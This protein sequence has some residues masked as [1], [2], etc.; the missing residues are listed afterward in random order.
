MRTLGFFAGALCA[1][2]TMF[3]ATVQARPDFLC[4]GYEKMENHAGV[5]AKILSGNT[6]YLPSRGTINTLVVFARFADED[7]GD[8]RLPDFADAL[9]AP[10]RPGSF[11]HFYHTMS[12]G[13][14]QVRGTVLPQRYASKRPQS[15]Y[16]A[17]NPGEPGRYRE[18]VQEILEKVDANYDLGQFDNDGP[19]NIPDSGDDDGIVDYIFINLLSVP[20]HFL[21]G[22][23]TG[24]AG[25]GLER[26]YNSNDLSF[27][28]DPIRIRDGINRGAI[29]QA[30]SFARTVG[31]M[32]HEFGHGLGLPDLYDLEYEDPAE[33]SAGIGDWGLMGW[34][35]DGWHGNDGPNPFCAWSLE[36]LGWIGRDNARLVQV[37]G[38][39]TGLALA[40]LHQQG[41]IC[42]IPLRTEFTTPGAIYVQE[43]LLL[44]ERVRTSHYY[45]RHLPAEGLLI[46]HIRP[47]ER[48]K[49]SREATKRV[50]LVCADGLYRDAGRIPDPHAGRDDLDFWAHE[51]SYAREHGGNLGDATDPFDG[52]H[53]TRFDLHTNP[54]TAIGG[55]H[56]PA[57]TGLALNLQRRGDTML[58]NIQQPRWSGTIREEVHWLGQVV[59]DGDLEIAPEGR[60]VVYSNTIVHVAGTD[61]LQRGQDPSRCELQVR[62]ELKIHTGTLY[63]NEHPRGIAPEP[64]IFAAL[65]PG[66]T[67][68]GIVFAAASRR[69][70]PA[71]G[72]VLR[73]SERGLVE[74]TGL[75][76]LEIEEPT[77]ILEESLTRPAT[78]QLLPNFPNPFNPQTTIQYVLPAAARVRL[79]VY[80]ALGQ[81]VRIL[82]DGFQPAGVQAAAWDGRDERGQDAASG[83]Y[84]YRLEAEG[85]GALHRRMTLLR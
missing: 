11:T 24:M 39:T 67:W 8:N 74:V 7:P 9:F 81:K 2:S 31:S 25:L 22:Q 28:G 72:F 34:G 78:F 63:S 77:A 6:S 21:Q 68:Y 17:Q 33:D 59:V 58:V 84:L 3:S 69:Q 49:N 20:H 16:L 53:N 62:G 26:E 64:A 14:L 27:R 65:V 48:N 47:Q 10:A 12:F 70:L 51:E 43:Y 85:M 19:D 42:K 50:D 80:N 56:H 32:A 71:N 36:Q 73:D 55:Q 57:S 5:A 75:A 23:A 18:F 52:V 13:Q 37:R 79:V 76:L 1:L 35:A 83:V 4:A 60:L 38:D 29:L 54:S 61:R 15:A 41:L 30:G 44:E 66:E 46:W 82:V 45:N 40:D